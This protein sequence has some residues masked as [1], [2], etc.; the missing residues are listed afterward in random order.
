VVEVCS[1]ETFLPPRP[2]EL[3]S[4]LKRL[5]PQCEIS[6]SDGEYED[7]CPRGCCAVKS[8][9]FRTKFQWST[10]PP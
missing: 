2:V 4:L 5:L 9:R 7:G 6:S 10:V 8:C 1:W 3:N